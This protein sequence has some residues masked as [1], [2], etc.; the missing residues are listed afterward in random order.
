MKEYMMELA[1]NLNKDFEEI[2]QE[3]MERD[4]EQ[5][6]IPMKEKWITHLMS[7]KNPDIDQLVLRYRTEK[8]SFDD[9]CREISP[10][11]FDIFGW[12]TFV[13]SIKTDLILED[14]ISERFMDDDIHD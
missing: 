3:D 1:D 11:K 6:N 8:I 7:V 12:N 14:T 13:K 10:I 4:F 2:T 9:L 5:R